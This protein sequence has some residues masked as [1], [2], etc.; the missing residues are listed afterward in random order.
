MDTGAASLVSA[1]L[2]LAC[3]S[4]ERGLVCSAAVRR[5]VATPRGF[6]RFLIGS[7]LLSALLATP[8]LWLWPTLAP[9]YGIGA[10][11]VLTGVLA[12]RLLHHRN[13]RDLRT[14]APWLLAASL[15]ATL[16]LALLAQDAQSALWASLA[17]ALALAIGL[18]AWAELARRLDDSDVPS[19]MR[20]LPARVLVC[21]IIVLALTGSLSW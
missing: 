7:V 18:P 20:P 1:S 16:P 4:A 10:G 5:L 13:A 6:A 12:A 3:L 9:A 11:L 15:C 21:G 14:A 19:R 2:T 8:I 17:M